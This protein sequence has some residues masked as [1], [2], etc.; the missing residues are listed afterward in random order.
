MD[1]Q[2]P[3]MDGLE[4]TAKIREM[5]R[6][7]GAYTPIVA[8]TAHTMKGDRERCL[9]AGMDS[10]INKPIDAAKFLEVLES[11]AMSTRTDESLNGARRPLREQRGPFV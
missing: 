5:E 10:Y 9:D 3:D 2:M 6:Q 11:L 4:A 8:L 1:V 7:T